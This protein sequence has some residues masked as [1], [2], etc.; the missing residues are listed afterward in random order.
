MISLDSELDKINLKTLKEQ[1]DNRIKSIINSQKSKNDLQNEKIDEAV[2][3][4]HNKKV[5][6]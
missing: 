1:K 6:F 3:R 5:E 4:R 2:N